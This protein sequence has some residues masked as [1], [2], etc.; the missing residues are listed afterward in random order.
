MMH[1][2]F[3]NHA[4]LMPDEIAPLLE[5]EGMKVGLMTCYDLRFPEPGAG[6]GITGS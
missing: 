3:R 4:V 6:T 1:L 5:V 2:P